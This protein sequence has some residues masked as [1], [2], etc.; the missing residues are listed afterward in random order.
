MK[1]KK[2]K[3]IEDLESLSDREL[4]YLIWHCQECGK[5]LIPDKESVVFKDEDESEEDYKK[6]KRWDGHTYKFDCD[7]GD[8][9]LRLMVG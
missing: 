6:R 5:K 3:S 1:I 7:C 4:E 9:N 8:P 2:I